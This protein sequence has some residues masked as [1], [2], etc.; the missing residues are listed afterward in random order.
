M[1]DSDIDNL[2]GEL[3]GMCHFFTWMEGEEGVG[4]CHRYPRHP[5]P[6][7]G[8]AYPLHHADDWCGE[9]RPSLESLN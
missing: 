4:V 3:C 2:G 1:P 8:A 7:G 9:F 6:G 5:I